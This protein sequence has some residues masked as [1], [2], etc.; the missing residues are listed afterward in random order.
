MMWRQMSKDQRIAA[1]ESGIASGKTITE[2]GAALGIRR[3]H[4]ARSVGH[5]CDANGVKYT[6]RSVASATNAPQKATWDDDD[7]D[8]LRAW[9]V[10]Q[11]KAFVAAVRK[12]HFGSREAVNS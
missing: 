1:I 8:A 12:R 6:L 3:D 5:F 11:D 9:I 7:T 4:A 10:R 2:I